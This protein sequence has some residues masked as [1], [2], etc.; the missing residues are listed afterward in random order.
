MSEEKP[1]LEK[2]KELEVPKKRRRMLMINP[3]DFMMLFKEGLEFRKHT[4][5]ITGLP[6]DAV[7]LAIAAEPVRNGIILVCESKEFDLV[8][9]NELPPTQLVE[10]EL[11]VPGATKKNKK[12]RKK[13]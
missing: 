4:K 2:M 9:I 3:P 8:P 5:L 12:P 11:G 6:E 1:D 7:L 10:I 13:K